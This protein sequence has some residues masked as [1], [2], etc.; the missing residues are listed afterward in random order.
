MIADLKIN[1]EFRFPLRN[2]FLETYIEKLSGKTRDRK[3]VSSRIQSLKLT[4][5]DSR[6][7]PSNYIDGYFVH[8]FVKS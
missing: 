3:Q 1:G 7:K 8:W 5:K 6:S 4:S 2:A